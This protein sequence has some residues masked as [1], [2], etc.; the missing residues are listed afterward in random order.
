MHAR[1]KG[2]AEEGAG[3][4]NEDGEP[5][6]D[7]RVIPGEARD[8]TLGAGLLLARV[9][10]QLEDAGHGRFGEGGL[11]LDADHAGHVDAA[12]NRRN[13]G[14]D[15]GRHALA[16][17]RA[18]VELAFAFHDLAVE[19]DA[20]AGLDD[21]H[22]AHGHRRRIDLYEIALVVLDVGEVGGDVHH[23]G[24]R[25]ARLV[26]RVAFEQLAYLVEEHDRRAFG[27]MGLSFGKEDQSEGAECGNRH[28]QILVEGLSVD[29]AVPGFGE[30]V[31][32]GQQVGHQ[33]EGELGPQAPAGG[34]GVEDVRDVGEQFEHEKDRKRDKDALEGFALL[35][36]EGVRVHEGSFACKRGGGGRAPAR[37]APR[38][39]VRCR[40]RS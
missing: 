13:A 23:G 40:R 29:D 1:G 32:A 17:K 15:H 30:H 2:F 12:R 19:R 37:R 28:E 35:F 25:L 24:D 16:G 8:E 39:R 33:K 38:S 36:R 5:H 4:G 10:H 20:L 9:L 14:F 18:R 26:G 6:H 3:H 34:Q 11:H 7:R 22:I 31:V 27:H 21:D